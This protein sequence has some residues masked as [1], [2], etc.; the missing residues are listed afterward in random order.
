MSGALQWRWITP[1]ELGCQ[2]DHGAM[3]RPATRYRVRINGGM[4]AEN[5]NSLATEFEHA[6]TTSPPKVS[7]ARFRKWLS[8]GVPLLTVRTTMP[9]TRAS[10]EERLS[11]LGANRQVRRLLAAPRP[12]VWD[13]PLDD[14]PD[15]WTA[16]TQLWYLRPRTK[17]D[18]GAHYRLQVEPGLISSAGPEPGRGQ[19]D[20]LDLHTFPK[21]AFLGVRCRSANRAQRRRH[22]WTTLPAQ[23]SPTADG[24]L[25][26]PE[27]PIGLSFSSPV[28]ARALAPGLRLEPPPS[29][30]SPTQAIWPHPRTTQWRYRPHSPAHPYIVWL[31]SGLAPSTTFALA[32]PGFM[33]TLVQIAPA[34]IRH[35][36]KTAALRPRLTLRRGKAVLESEFDTHVPL[37]VTNLD[38]VDY[39]FRRLTSAGPSGDIYH[40]RNVANIENKRQRIR[41]SAR[42]LLDSRSGVIAGIA[43]TTPRVVGSGQH[44]FVQVT[45]FQVHV[46]LGHFRSLAWV[47][48]LTTGA[49]VKGATV[50]RYTDSYAKLEGP[51]HDVPAY[52]TDEQGLVELPGTKGVDPKQR[53]SGR[54]GHADQRLF[55]HVAR[56]DAM[57]LVPLDHEFR[58]WG[59]GAW[60]VGKPPFGHL[61]VWG[62][63]AQGVYRAGQTIHYKLYVRDQNDDRLVPAPA[64]SYTVRIRDPLGRIIIT[65]S[66]VTLSEF[67]THHGEITTAPNAAVGWYRFE[68]EASYS[69]GRWNAMEVLVSDFSPAPFAVA[70]EL[71]GDR[72]ST[73]APIDV[74]LLANLHAGGPFQNAPTRIVAR[75]QSRPFRSDHPQAARFSFTRCSVHG[76]ANVEVHR[77]QG[78]LNR[79]GTHRTQLR[80][81]PRQ[82][83]AAGLQYGELIVEGSVRDERGKWISA[84]ARA[85]V[86]GAQ[87]FT[88]LRATRWI[89]EQRRK[90]AIETIVLDAGG[91]LV[92]DTAISV[93]VEQMVSHVARV[94]SAGTVYTPRY[95]RVWE[96]V[97]TCALT[98]GS[99]IRT[100]PFTPQSPGT[101]RAVSQVV[102]AQQ[103]S[104]DAEIQF[105]VAGEGSV[106]W[107]TPENGSLSV[108][109]ERTRLRLGETARFLVRNPFPG[110]FGLVTVERY[111]VL[112]SWVERFDT[113][114]PVIKVPVTPNMVPGFFL[115]VT[116]VSP[117]IG[118]PLV[119][120]PGEENPKRQLD[121]QHDKQWD[122][123]AD[124]GMP[125]MR[126]GY[127]RCTVTD[128][129][130]ELALSVTTDKPVYRPG[131]AVTV[132]LAHTTESSRLEA[133]TEG[134][135]SAAEPVEV[136]I[137]VIDESVLALNRHGLA[138]YDAGAGLV[139]LGELD[140]RNFNLLGQLVGRQ[141]LEAKG[142][143]SGGG[144]TSEG[145]R[146]NFRHLAHWTG[147]MKLDAHGQGRITLQAPDNLTGWRILVLALTR[148]D[149]FGLSQGHFKVNR[150]TELRPILPNQVSLGDKFR[151]GF[152][153]FNRTDHDRTLDVTVASSSAH[154]RNRIATENHR[155]LR[156][157]ARERR[158]VWL[159]VEANHAGGL[160]LRA[161]A[162]DRHDRDRIEAEVKVRDIIQTVSMA[163]F[164]TT[165]GPAHRE[166]VLVPKGSRTDVGGLHIQISPTVI[167]NLGGAFRYLRDYPYACWEQRLTK[168][169]MAMQYGSLNA[170]L[171]TSVVW[172][173]APSLPARALLD[174]AQ[175][176][177][178]NGGM[179]YWV[180]EDRYTS[181]YLSAFTGLAFEWFRAGG[182]PPPA[183]VVDRL[184][185]YL[186]RMFRSDQAPGSGGF[187]AGWSRGSMA[188]AR[189]VAAAGLALRGKL[190]ANDL[191]RY[192]AERPQLTLFARA[193][194]LAGA[195]KVPDSARLTRELADDLL[196]HADFSSGK[197]QLS[198]P[199]G[200]PR[201]H[202]SA[203]RSICAA[204]SV[205]TAMSADPRWADKFSDLPPRMVRA[206]SQARGRKGH[207]ENT[208]ENLF[209]AEALSAYARVFEPV[210]PAM[211][212]Q[213]WL[214]NEAL[215][216]DRAD[217]PRPPRL[218]Q[219][220]GGGRLDSILAPPIVLERP[221]TAGEIGVR[222]T[223]TVN[224]AGTG[225]V[226][227]NTRL[228]YAPLEP[229]RDVIHA[230]IEVNRHYDIKRNGTWHPAQVPVVMT[231]GD[232]VRIRLLV[233]VPAP[234]YFVVVDDPVPGAL[235]P[236]DANLA[237]TAHGDS[238]SAG[239][240]RLRSGGPK[241]WRPEFFYHRELGHRAARFYA[242]YLPRGKHVLTYI[243]QA[244]STGTFQAPATRA[245]EMYEPDVFGLGPPARFV[246]TERNPRG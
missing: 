103:R 99:G 57:A 128:P 209:C 118:Q 158:A 217:L 48:D 155:S 111:G 170:H 80:L 33:D 144:G 233:N 24:L 228:T 77:T 237:T 171:G 140:V 66:N 229:S 146:S 208:Q 160:V 172:P 53:L 201:I 211:R 230:G 26:D 60:A 131:E 214:S 56:G 15:D 167:G 194:L 59:R 175:F 76:S 138:H 12:D 235:E 21:P 192:L 122:P 100:C 87:R 2:L 71:P 79:S 64:D 238:D 218:V 139:A 161:S 69:H 202:A 149:R 116:V 23:P 137:A 241:G 36:F 10:I 216:V 165:T 222:Q 225:R 29:G 186:E 184:D 127:V 129:A 3:L 193:M 51:A 27:E 104:H 142:A 133:R 30:R 232:L 94:K 31:P 1:R 179:A 54:I 189:A 5:G 123:N 117:R 74:D 120:R 106:V 234:R 207:W 177:A 221:T 220:L 182:H 110:A 152:S 13:R 206:I 75:V 168:G 166:E 215:G 134:Q 185:D 4:T 25:C 17:L 245:E 180:A 187:G 151:A 143:S 150:P 9:V 169:L 55:V 18:S 19:R 88:G 39:K 203:L 81:D 49:P 86:H 125:T 199:L 90:G 92:S 14:G 163:N 107:E 16:P 132:T 113:A 28:S 212:V 154:D 126:M 198:E 58:V 246:V 35:T 135:G 101:Y 240:V 78:R 157:S 195:L 68:V 96:P 50:K 130:K 196:A 244:I 7:R 43:R 62:T 70:L 148:D 22:R 67:G 191:E 239:G 242:D 40:Q 183:A 82:L 83:A 124:L 181:P 243:A 63:T 52:T 44:F 98:P 210:S 119:A 178:P 176:Q 174:A 223:L 46:K 61:R 112:R 205:V 34:P 42:A 159:D 65:K 200:S 93:R 197:V 147:A 89:Y 91:D 213:A 6:F 47:T 190:R 236:V 153:I 32:S 11:L 115:S 145:L 204:L 105:W 109:A 226:Y 136:A 156:L 84:R 102:D 114:T 45:P 108:V 164:S 188:T 97:T 173:G 219:Q 85:T 162:G 38:S 141:R 224:K 37:T 20:L 121:P 72:F 73:D 41:P 231:R 227:V 8:P 95:S